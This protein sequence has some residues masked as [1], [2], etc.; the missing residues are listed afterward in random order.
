MLHADTMYELAK[1]RI[2][3]DLRRAERERLVRQA[4]AGR[5]SGAIDAVPFR[6]RLARLFGASWP[7]ARGGLASARG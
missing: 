7:A 6:E 5:E 4:G 1:L 3:E 2:A